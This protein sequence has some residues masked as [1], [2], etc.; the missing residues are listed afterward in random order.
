MADFNYDGIIYGGQLN[1]L[2]DRLLK[3]GVRNLPKPLVCLIRIL[4]VK[5]IQF[6]HEPFSNK[7][8]PRNIV[9]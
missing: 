3:Q 8:I 5:D 9:C 6:Q 7:L 1:G 2:T 4:R